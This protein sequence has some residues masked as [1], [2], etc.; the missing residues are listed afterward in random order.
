[1][2]EDEHGALS[3]ITL[4]ATKRGLRL[5]A[6]GRIVS[7]AREI[8]PNL[9]S[10]HGSVLHT[11]VR[12]YLSEPGSGA[13]MDEVTLSIHG[14]EIT[15]L[16][17]LCHIWG[18]DTGMW[19]GLDPSDVVTP[20]GSL[21]A[22]ISHWAGGILTRGVFIDIPSR[23][24]GARY[25]E[26]DKPVNASELDHALTALGQPPVAG[27]AL[28]VRCGRNAWEVDHGSYGEVSPRP[29]LDETCVDVLRKWGF[30]ILVSDMVDVSPKPE[31]RKWAAHSAIYRLGIGFVDNA[32]L[33]ELAVVCDEMDRYDFLL[34]ISALPIKG[35]SGSPVNPLAVF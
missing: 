2:V 29:G 14:Y 26:A 30:S 32:E 3:L 8:V 11:P 13:M 23:R 35:A 12:S 10:K 4:A 9:D 33:D 25:V 17:A 20:S 34:T 31:G 28:V 15:H 7:M 18:G 1:M 5:A 6:Q 21:W 22:D 24:D 19:G 16:D 27:D